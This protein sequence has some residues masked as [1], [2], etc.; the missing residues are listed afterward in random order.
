[1]KDRSNVEAMDERFIYYVGSLP[2]AICIRLRIHVFPEPGCENKAVFGPGGSLTKI[3]RHASGDT[4]L[5]GDP[6][7]ACTMLSKTSFLLLS[8]DSSRGVAPRVFAFVVDEGER[9]GSDIV[10]LLPA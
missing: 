2:V 6:G 8:G 3:V 1:M 10:A 9:G 5:P 4:A 7:P